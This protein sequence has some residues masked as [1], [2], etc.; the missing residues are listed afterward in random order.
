MFG[1]IELFSGYDSF[2]YREGVSSKIITWTLNDLYIFIHANNSKIYPQLI[3][4][5]D[6]IFHKNIL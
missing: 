2:G 5:I 1:M 3:L 4:S 6:L